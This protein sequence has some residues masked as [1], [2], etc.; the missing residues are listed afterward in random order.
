MPP[1][2]RPPRRP[3]TPTAAACVAL[4]LAAAPLAGQVE[5]RRASSALDASFGAT[6]LRGDVAWTVGVAGL[7]G[8]TPRLS[9]GGAGTLA[10]EPVELPGAVPGADLALRTALGGA[11]AQWILAEQGPRRVWARLLAGA[12][13]AKVDLA[14]GG[15]RIAADNFGVLAP[16]LGGDVPLAGPLRAGAALGYR[17]VFGVEDL[18][19]VGPSDL[20]GF[21]FRVLVGLGHP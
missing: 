19:G 7:L 14:A 20:R 15:T 18:P 2:R 13:S 6:T 3:G 8:L 16:E 12:G 21:T 11:V 5:A 10:L 4:L 17:A 1:S 9:V